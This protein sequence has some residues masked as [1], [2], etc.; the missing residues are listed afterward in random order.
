MKRL[1]EFMYFSLEDFL[2]DKRLV[3]LKAA[4]W[5]EGEG[6]AMSL[7]GSRVTVQIIEDNTQY[8]KD[9]DNFGAQ[10]IVKVR[11]MSPAAYGKWKPLQTEVVITDV[12]KAT[13]WGEF[14]NE[15]SV[16][17]VVKAKAGG[18]AQ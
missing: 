7:E 5:N 1:S 17:A 9:V 8:A 12:E 16:I 14:R 15:L 13:V 18:A 6:Q 10:F 11:G 3:Y 2:A 4:P